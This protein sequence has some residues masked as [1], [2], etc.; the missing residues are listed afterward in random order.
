MWLLFHREGETHES[1]KKNYRLKKKMDGLKNDDSQE[2]VSLPCP[3]QTYQ[4]H[5][6]V[7][8]VLNKML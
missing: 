7:T 3:I 5:F 6:R 4:K 2:L 1:V 8:N